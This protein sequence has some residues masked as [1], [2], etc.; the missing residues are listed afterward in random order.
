MQ[1]AKRCYSK[2]TLT[3]RLTG[4]KVRRVVL[5]TVIEYDFDPKNSEIF[6]IRFF[7]NQIM[8]CQNKKHLQR[9]A[10]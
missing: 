3:S 10:L 2:D 4:V 8:F 9:S 1:I 6:G 5:T 7:Y